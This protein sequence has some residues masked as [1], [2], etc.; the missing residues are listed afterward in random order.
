ME[1]S[2]SYNNIFQ[3]GV[4]RNKHKTKRIIPN[5]D[6]YFMDVKCP[7]CSSILIIFSHSQTRVKCVGCDTILCTPT[8]GKV[9]LI[10]GASFIKKQ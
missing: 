9:R 1:L 6:S 3:E 7:K 8:G 10:I 4:E 2:N 5:P